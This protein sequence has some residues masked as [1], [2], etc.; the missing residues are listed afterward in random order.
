MTA[1]A[2]ALPRGHLIGLLI[3]AVLVA[4]VEWLF[5][6]GTLLAPWQKLP[7]AD[8]ALAL[9]LT[10]ASYWA[11]AQRQYDY[12]QARMRGAYL[13][14]VR[15]ML[16]HNLLNNL[17]P[18][19]AGEL[20][21]PV[22]MARYFAVPPAQSLPALLLFRM[23]D[24]HTL[25]AL[26]LLAAG[27]FWLPAWAVL[28]LALPW[29][30]LPWL[31]Y[32]GQRSLQLHLEARPGG[33][34]RAL[35]RRLL[36]GLP[37]TAPAFRRAWAWTVVNW[38]VKLGVFAWM[39]RLFAELPLAAAWIG[40]IGGDLTSVLPFHA[41]AGAGTYEAGIAGGVMLF[42]VPLG[43][44]LPAAINLHLFVLGSALA[45]GLLAVFLPGRS[46]HG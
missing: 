11:R 21:F 22:L 17:L 40:A 39:L 42:D 44:A 6:W 3:L 24:L 35:L 18:M 14:G 15:L 33:A 28:A 36:E 19:R 45:G 27:H 32:R 26:A 43:A 37:Q 23:L 7:A 16:E 20:S 25:A 34:A 31:L 10:F 29:L 8:I 9:A 41:V 13:T 1:I 30:A 5:G 4:A 12:F 2:R 38:V 46:N